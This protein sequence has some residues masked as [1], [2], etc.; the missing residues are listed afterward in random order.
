MARSVHTIAL[1]AGGTGGHMFPAQSLA[2]EARRRGWRVILLTDARGQRYTDGFPADETV[3]LKAANPNVRGAGAKLGMAWAMA[4]GT[5]TASKVLRKRRPFVTVG[6]GGYPSAPAMFAAK[7]AG[8]RHGVHEQNAVLGR[9]NRRVAPSADFVAHGFARLDRLGRA[10]GEVVHTGNPV[11]EA[12]RQAVRPYAAPSDT[13]NVLVFGGSQ[14]ASLFSRVFPEALSALPEGVRD[15]L[16]VTQQVRDEEA[17]AVAATYRAAGIRAELA[18]FFAD[19]PRRMAEAHL[20][21]GRSGASTVT[22]LSV[23][24]RPSLLVPLG[25]AMDDHQKANAEVLTAS[26]AARMIEE[27]ALNAESARAAL[28]DLL[29]GECPLPDM[30]ERALGL[31]PDDAAGRLADLCEGLLGAA[32]RTPAA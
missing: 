6:F 13:A 17:D 23:M 3:S 8:L 1:A 29:V 4:G 14:G 28:S 24:G 12:V 30:A 25:I 18:P 21:I 2:E 22:E 26:G 19:L 5:R 32:A 10:R 16:R 9:V 7:A 20:V 31:V 11:R 15:R 27:R